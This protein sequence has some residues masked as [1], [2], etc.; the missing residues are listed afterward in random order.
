MMMIL[1]AVYS[2]SV[3][4]F[5]SGTFLF[6]PRRFL[7][8]AFSSRQ[9]K[10]Q[11]HNEIER[12][13]ELRQKKRPKSQ[14]KVPLCV[15]FSQE[16]MTEKVTKEINFQKSNVTRESSRSQSPIKRTNER[17]DGISIIL[18]QKKETFYSCLSLKPSIRFVHRKEMDSE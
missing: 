16:F 10:E 4:P 11:T 2:F 13:D 7:F 1:E 6:F 18:L 12:N 14:V 5:H 15:L 3:P 9:R 8:L 17:F